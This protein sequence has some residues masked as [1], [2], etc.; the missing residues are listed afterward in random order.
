MDSTNLKKQLEDGL[1]TFFDQFSPTMQLVD[2]LIR[3]KTHPQEILILL[4]SRLDAL[5]S[6]AEREDE[7]RRKTFT[8]FVT[9]YGGCRD[10][11]KSV[12][13]GDLYY[14]VGYH[15]WLLPGGLIQ[16]PGRI[17]RFSA[18][19]DPFIRLLEESGIALTVEEVDRL[20]SGIMRGLQENFR[21]MARQ[22]LTRR[23]LGTAE[24]ILQA[25][26]TKFKGPRS[27]VDGRLL[28]EKLRPMLQDKTIASLLYE[29]FRCGA[30]HGGRVRL[31]EDRFFQEEE[32]YW[33][34]MYS[35]HYGS[36][37]L[38]EF[39]A[40]FLLKLCRQCMTTYR[41]HLTSKGKLPPDVYF[42]IFGDRILSKL[43]LLDES[44]LPQ[45]QSVPLKLPTR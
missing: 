13:A 32:P 42:Q 3:A 10:V 36:F 5:A 16:K 19:N 40:R 1:R 14:E 43:T 17:H 25:I 26:V 22:P 7:P 15:R 27:L 29:R 12:S 35:E 45:M 2:D 31:N 18:L 39:P 6:S 21:V 4:C 38:I 8:A 41:H 23:P 34:T 11:F 9:A 37:L 28:R 33:E 44:L 24:H 20:L 30:I